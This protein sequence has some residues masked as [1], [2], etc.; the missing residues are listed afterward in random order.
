MAR[1]IIWKKKV[2]ISTRK[3]CISFQNLIDNSLSFKIIDF[4]FICL[5][6]CAQKKQKTNKV[7]CFNKTKTKCLVLYVILFFV[8]FLL[9]YNK[10]FMFRKHL[11]Q[12][13]WRA[14]TKYWASPMYD[15]YIWKKNK[16]LIK[17]KKKK[18]QKIKMN[19]YIKN[20]NVQSIALEY[21]LKRLFLC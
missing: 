13:F 15:K 10:Y 17:Q 3:R 11:C 21:W 20:A 4:D 18:K 8:F 16:L 14:Q 6:W 2:H 7:K 19:K 12:T 5:H 9:Q 1:E